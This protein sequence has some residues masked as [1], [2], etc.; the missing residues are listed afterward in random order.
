[1]TSMFGSLL[2][3]APHWHYL[4]V[5]VVCVLCTAP[6]ELLFGARVYARWRRAAL[7]IVIGAAPFVLWDY[8]AIRAGDWEISPSHTIGVMI[9]VFPIEELLFFVVIPL[10]GLLT[11]EAVG[12]VWT[13]LRPDDS[14]TTSPSDEGH[15]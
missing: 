9:G 11:Y 5:L 10:C 15:S 6:L 12:R 1:M 8:L 14:A 13:Q 4:A 3:V 7:A 2:D